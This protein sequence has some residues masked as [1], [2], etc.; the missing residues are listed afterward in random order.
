MSGKG[1]VGCAGAA[2][3]EAL[4]C[5]RGAPGDVLTLCLEVLGAAVVRR[6]MNAGVGIARVDREAKEDV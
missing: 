1:E 5:I 6:A 3:V 2:V 4:R